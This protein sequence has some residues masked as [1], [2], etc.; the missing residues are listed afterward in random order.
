MKI[1]RLGDLWMEGAM[2]TKA[3]AAVV[4]YSKVKQWEKQQAK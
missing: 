1:V 3:L 2:D 4:L